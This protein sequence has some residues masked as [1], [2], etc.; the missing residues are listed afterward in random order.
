VRTLLACVAALGFASRLAAADP[1]AF[2]DGDRVALIGSTLIEREQRYGDWE[3]A[4]TLANADKNVTFRNLGWSGDTVWGEA[5]NGFDASPKGFERLVQIT[6]DVKPTVVVICYGHNES[7]DGPAGVPKFTAQL[8]KLLDAIAPTKARVVLMSPTPFLKGGPADPEPR[9]KN[10]ALYRDAMKGVA[11]KRGHGFVDLFARHVPDETAHPIT[12]NGMH[13]TA[14]GYFILADRLFTDPDGLPA[15]T[16]WRGALLRSDGEMHRLRAKV[17]EK[18]QLFFH[19]WRPQ[20]ET[21]LYLFRKHEQGNNAK[22]IPEFDPLVEKAEK[23]IA[24]LVKA[25]R[26]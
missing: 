9:N 6:K 5:R 8:E 3:L 2:K 19:R 18:N 20:N 13:L 15:Y 26:K 1:F 17:V 14:H 21:Y 12:D 16:T 22:E 25:L 7:F 24:E 4:L 10:L 11:D 23:E